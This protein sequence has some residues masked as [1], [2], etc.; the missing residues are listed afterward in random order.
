MRLDKWLKVARIF[1]TRSRAAEACEQRHVKVN[2]QTA[3][4]AKVIRIGDEIT[5]RFGNRFRTLE[6]KKVTLKS[7]PA[8]LAAELYSE[9]KVDLSDE[10]MEL[11][12]VM[13]RLDRKF[14]PK[15]KGRPTKKER[16]QIE[17]L[18]GF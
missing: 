6:I 12:Q 14:R 10:S 9:Q 18:K 4:P 15:Y 5:V 3:K 1:K 17:K 16:R 7:L 13:K 8:A 2:G 11:M